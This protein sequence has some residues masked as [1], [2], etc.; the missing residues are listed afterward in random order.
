[1]LT[2]LKD[3]IPKQ[4]I[5]VLLDKT[6]IS[7]VVDQWIAFE[8]FQIYHNNKLFLYFFILFLFFL[9]NQFG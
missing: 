9:I 1:M 7:K 2:Q 4:R 6:L 8:N 3:W 5:I